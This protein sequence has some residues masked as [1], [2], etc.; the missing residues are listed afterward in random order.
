M[1]EFVTC[2]SESIGPLIK[3]LGLN[4]CTTSVT[5]HLKAGEPVRMTTERF[6]VA[7][8]VEELRG[9]IDGYF[10]LESASYSLLNG[11]SIEPEP[12]DFW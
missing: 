8:E 3:G 2:N 7:Y 12:T 10:V 9:W 1:A 11:T 4:G 6:L 5:I